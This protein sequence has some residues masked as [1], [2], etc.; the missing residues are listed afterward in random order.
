MSTLHTQSVRCTAVASLLVAGGAIWVE[1]APAGRGEWVFGLETRFVSAD[2][3]ALSGGQNV[4]DD[5]GSFAP[6]RAPMDAFLVVD[7][8]VGTATVDA[9]SDQDSIV[10][11]TRFVARGSASASVSTGRVGDSAVANG[12]SKY[13][14]NF[15]ISAP[16]RFRLEASLSETGLGNAVVEISQNFVVL[17]SIRSDDPVTSVRE[18]ITLPAGQYTFRAETQL[19]TFLFQ[20]GMVSGAGEYEVLFAPSNATLVGD[21][22]CDGIVSVGD[23]GAFVLALTDPAG[24]AAQFPQCEPD[25]GDVNAD[26]NVTVGDIGGFVTLLTGE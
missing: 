25:N 19:S 22:N 23:I 15:S 9:F 18:F 1:P 13:E 5:Q 12:R 2:G 11:S 17:R 4:G 24:Y 21:L 10:E 20:P 3:G 16:T 26:G 6:L 7:L 14:V 8:A